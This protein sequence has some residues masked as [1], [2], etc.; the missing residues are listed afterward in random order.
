MAVLGVPGIAVVPGGM[1]EVVIRAALAGMALARV[2]ITLALDGMVV[3]VTGTAVTGM[4]G[5]VAGTMVVTAAAGELAPRLVSVLALDYSE[6]RSQRLPIMLAMITAP[7]TRRL[8]VHPRLRFGIG[9]ML[10]R[11]ITRRYLNA[12]FRGDKLFSSQ[13]INLV[14]LGA[15]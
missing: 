4:V 10:I 9:A 3:A 6:E 11:A 15:A 13:E 7:I 2:G 12:R 5:V 1:E 8:A 14:R